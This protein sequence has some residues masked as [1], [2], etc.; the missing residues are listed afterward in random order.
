MFGKLKKENEFL[1]RMVAVLLRWVD[2]RCEN[3]VFRNTIPQSCG[4]TGCEMC[5][6]KEKGTSACCTCVDGCNFLW[7]GRDE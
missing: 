1:K 5:E 2:D 7:N 3:C 4:Q 6:S